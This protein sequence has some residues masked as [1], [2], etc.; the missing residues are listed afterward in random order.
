MVKSNWFE[1]S[2]MAALVA[3]WI[4][5]VGMLATNE[6]FRNAVLNPFTTT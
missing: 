6:A 2:I 3:F 4:F 5:F 1:L